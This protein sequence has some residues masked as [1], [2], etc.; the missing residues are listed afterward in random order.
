MPRQKRMKASSK[1]YHV[2]IRG[3]NKQDIFLDKQD[4]LKFIK[5]VERTKEKYEYE[6]YAYSLMSDHVHII[7]YDKNNNMSIAMQSLEI[8]YS[9]Y[10]NKKYERKGHLFD[11][12]FRNKIVEDR[13]YLKNLVRYIHKNP[14]NA[15][16]KPYE[17]TSYNEYLYNEKIISKNLILKLFGNTFIEAINNFKI[18][19]KNYNRYQ[20]YD[21][22]YEFLTSITDEEAI[23]I[24]KNILMEENLLKIQQYDKKKRDISIMKI[25]KIEGIK[26]QQIS[27]IIGI[28]TKT[29]KKIELRNSKKKHDSD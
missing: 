17:W 27:R 8:S 22:D 9:L 5:E 24:I 2:M 18:F 14:E 19:H 12:R 11:N 28:S 4:L 21:K 6:I 23:K 3:I 10:F 13:N 7:I 29:I 26:K 16:L 25:L 15:G 20:D 1:V